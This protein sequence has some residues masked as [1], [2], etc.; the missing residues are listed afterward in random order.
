VLPFFNRRLYQLQKEQFVL[1][2]EN[3]RK[4]SLKNLLP[5]NEYGDV[6]KF[7]ILCLPLSTNSAQCSG[8]KFNLGSGY[9]LNAIIF[10]AFY[11]KLLSPALHA[12]LKHGGSHFYCVFICLD[13]KRRVKLLTLLLGVETHLHD[14]SLVTHI[15]FIKLFIKQRERWKNA[16]K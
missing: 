14:A 13:I 15:I 8:A 3:K 5:G 4:Q 10:P 16:L 9:T 1:S 7:S 11:D 6:L 2:S 12:V